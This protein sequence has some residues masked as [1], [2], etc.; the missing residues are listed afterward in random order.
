EK[1]PAI[2]FVPY[3]LRGATVRQFVVRT[4]GDPKALLNQIRGEM[5]ALDKELPFVQP[6]TVDE[7]LDREVA[8][9]RF[10]MALFSGLGAVALALAAAGIYS[11]LS[12]TVAQ[13]TR[14]IGL[15][16]A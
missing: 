8:P 4:H 2:V 12:Y 9:P 3:T 13:R 10:N 15:R 1:P 6:R 7:I 11:V 16:M 14:E 5:R